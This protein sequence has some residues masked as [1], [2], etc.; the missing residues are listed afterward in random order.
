MISKTKIKTRA[1]NKTNPVLQ[2]TIS[3][4]MKNQAWQNLSRSL[5]SSTRKF[6]SIN[7]FEIEKQTTPGDT[8]VIPGKVLSKGELTKKV[9]ICALSFSAEAKEKLKETKSE[10]VSI[11][12]EIKKNPKA[13][14]VKVLK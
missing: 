4:A 10:A 7:L 1:R 5:S 6:S 8:V 2:E 13:E 11:L 9:R 14:G 12:E 3:V